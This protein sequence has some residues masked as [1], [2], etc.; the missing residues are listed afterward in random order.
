MAARAV[1]VYRLPGRPNEWFM[2][3]EVQPQAVASPNAGYMYAQDDR[4]DTMVTLPTQEAAFEW[5]VKQPQSRY[6]MGAGLRSNSHRGFFLGLDVSNYHWVPTCYDAY[7][8]EA[9]APHAEPELW[10]S[11][12]IRLA[13]RIAKAKAS[14]TAA[15]AEAPAAAAAKS[16]DSKESKARD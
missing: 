3:V 10:S 15:A 5:W 2:D 4:T 1:Y 16:P 6:R 14:A 9:G 8:G 7:L 12:A 11:P 13:Q